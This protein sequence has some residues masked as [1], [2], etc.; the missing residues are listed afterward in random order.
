MPH[1]LYG[2]VAG[3]GAYS[4][5][6][7]LADA[8]SAR[9]KRP[10]GGLAADHHRRHRALFQGAGTGAGRHPA[11]PD[12]YPREMARRRRRPSC[13]T[14]PSAT[15]AWPRGSSPM[16]GS[17]SSGALEVF[18]ATGRSLVTGSARRIV[19]RRSRARRSS[20]FSS[21]PTARSSTAARMTASPNGQGGR[22]R[23]GQGACWRWSSTPAAD[24]EGDRRSGSSRPA[25][26][27]A[28]ATE[29]AIEAGQDR[30]PALYQA[31]ADLVAEPDAGLAGDDALDLFLTPNVKGSP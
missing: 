5:A 3:S 15:K 25:I 14:S 31:A 22:G 13:R 6:R 10:G 17:G 18:E 27:L 30:D 12:R 28:R 1:R 21:I 2:H 19:R 9:S 23:G 8:H 24:H 29:D 16:T 26:R 7:W 11:D 20:G 4:V